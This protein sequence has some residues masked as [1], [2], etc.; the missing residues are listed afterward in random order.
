[1]GR[2]KIASVVQAFADLITVARAA[3]PADKA[4]IYTGPGLRLACQPAGNLSGTEVHVSPAQYR[5]FESV[6]GR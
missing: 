2:D 3:T 5:Q 4:Q 1:M 6:R